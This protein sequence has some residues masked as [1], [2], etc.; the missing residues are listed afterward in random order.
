MRFGKPLLASCPLKNCS[1]VLVGSI[2]ASKC[3]DLPSYSAAKA[4]LVGLMYGAA[5][6]FTLELGVRINIVAPGTVYSERTQQQPK[7]WE[8]L[9]KHALLPEFPQADEIAQ[10]MYT[11]SHR[12]PHCTQQILTID[13]GQTAYAPPITFYIFKH[14]LWKLL[15]S[16][17]WRMALR[18]IYDLLEN[19]EATFKASLP[20]RI[21]SDL[22]E[23]E[24]GCGGYQI[25]RLEHSLQSA[26]RAL[27]DG[28]DEPYVVA[29]LVHDIGELI[30]P[31]SHG[32]L[33]AAV[34]KPF[35]SEKFTG[36][37]D[38]IRFSSIT[39]P[40]NLLT[41]TRIAANSFG[42]VPISTIAQSSV[43]YMT[44]TA[45]TRTTKVSH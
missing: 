19:A 12:L 26:T 44:K 33:A 37:S 23:I 2:N 7:D 6:E 22:R 5:R 45:S 24:T 21:L 42:I 29:C 9:A 17:A 25:S 31:W 18:Q 40:G 8:A 30:A 27:R 20:D 38:T 15:P 32:E 36:S 14:S 28:R 39:I 10:A 41:E 34:L 11:F 43:N 16:T 1:I 35:V 13:S 4:G 3:F